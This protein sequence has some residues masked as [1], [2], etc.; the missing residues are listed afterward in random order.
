MAEPRKSPRAL[1]RSFPS[2]VAARAGPSS[3][4][5]AFELK[6]DTLRQTLAQ[7]DATSVCRR[8]GGGGGDD[9]TEDAACDRRID[10]TIRCQR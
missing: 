2:A 6:L 4:R 10:R 5:H 3:S 1:S 8:S 7:S 9:V